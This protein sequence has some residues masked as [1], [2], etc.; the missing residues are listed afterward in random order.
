MEAPKRVFPL[1]ANGYKLYEEIG[2]GVSASVHRALCI[3]L[4]EIVA[5]KVLDLEKCNNDFDGIRR[6]VQ[7]MSLISHPN[8]LRAYCSFPAGQYLWVVMP[9]MAAGSC[10]HI[11]KSSFPD[12]FEE[13]V[14][15][16]LLREVLRGLVYLHNHG[17]IHRDVKAGNI[18]AD[19]NGS[20][21]LADFGVSA[22]MFDAGDRQRSRNTFVGTPCWMAPEVMQQ[23]HGYDFKADVWSFG[24]TALELA[25]GHAPFSK[26][27]PMKVLL[28]TLQNAPP[29]LDYERD[30]KFS[31]SFKDMVAACLVK[32]PKKRP[33]S[34]KLLK[35]PFFRHAKTA[36]Y[37][38]RTIINGLSPLGDRFRM[39]KAKEADLLL[40]NKELY[41]NEHL[42][43]QEYIRGISA[44][45]FDLEDLKSQAALI[46][47]LDEIQSVDEP[48]SLHQQNGPSGVTLPAEKFPETYN[49]HSDTKSSIGGSS[50][51]TADDIPNLENSFAAFPIAPLQALEGCFDISEDDAATV[52]S[53]DVDENPL[54][55]EQ[56][57]PVKL[58]TKGMDQET[59]KDGAE[60]LGQQKSIQ[61]TTIPGPR[62]AMSGSL[63]PENVVSP[64]KL[65]GNGEREYKS[66]FRIERNHSGPLQNLQKNSMTNSLSV[67]NVPEGSVVQRKGRFKITADSGPKPQ[68]LNPSSGGMPSPPTPSIP[69]AS[70]LPSLQSI[71]QHNTTQR[72]EI[73]RLIKSLDQTSGSS[74]SSSL[75]AGNSGVQVETGNNGFSQV[76]ELYPNK[77]FLVLFTAC[78]II[79]FFNDSFNVNSSLNTCRSLVQGRENCILR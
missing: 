57:L 16:T 78:L 70:L 42:S 63:L 76:M 10:L 50:Q 24:I 32:D 7:T 52:S 67:D 28:M 23:L 47:D 27:P 79:Y 49:D 55:T 68:V 35:H 5:I 62:K 9:Y 22:C 17:H 36:D 30:K 19:S 38:E 29:G 53:T 58:P 51:D 12:G 34:E 1:D 44:W 64:N 2:E 54:D 43:Q 21:K 13:P 20:I 26:Y 6:E 3:P 18:L 71:L 48:K 56:K 73:L 39:L 59:D 25:H 14:I 75:N 65:V 40:Q 66:R 11:M 41:E 15:A 46:N 61:K 60:I 74:S 4:N 69:A 72:E 31:K 37:L 45:N 8:L 33:N 77:K